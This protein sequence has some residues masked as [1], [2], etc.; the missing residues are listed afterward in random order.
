MPATS[1]RG[2]GGG[3]RLLAHERGRGH[4]PAGHSVDRVVHED[5]RELL[6]AVGGMDDLC[7]ADRGEVAV[8]LVAD[9]QV[10]GHACA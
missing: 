2:R 10:I 4:L 9:H 7:R 8:A 1:G 5:R 6:A 3:R